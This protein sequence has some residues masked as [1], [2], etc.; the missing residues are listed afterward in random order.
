LVLK[1]PD[2]IAGSKQRFAARLPGTIAT[3]RQ[4]LK[5]PR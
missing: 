4:A 2:K 1:A 3:T 5:G